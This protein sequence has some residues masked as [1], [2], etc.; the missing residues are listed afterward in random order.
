MVEFKIEN[1]LLECKGTI[2]KWEGCGKY[3]ELEQGDVKFKPMSDYPL[4]FTCKHC[5]T[6]IE[7]KGDFDE[8]LS[9]EDQAR[10][11]N[12]VAEEDTAEEPEGF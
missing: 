10:Y 2:R 7:V 3:W 5:G 9:K 6:R 11:S 12:F 8:F 4:Q 1:P